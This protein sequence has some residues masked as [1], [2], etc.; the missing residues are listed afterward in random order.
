MG[1]WLDGMGC[2]AMRRGYVPVIPFPQ[3]KSSDWS[4]DFSWEYSCGF[5]LGWAG[6]GCCWSVGRGCKCECEEAM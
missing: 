4:R 3:A 2:D 6:T 1:R 5:V